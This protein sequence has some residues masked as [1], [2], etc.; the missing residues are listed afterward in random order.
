MLN[1]SNHQSHNHD[2]GL[3]RSKLLLRRNNY[4]LRIVKSTGA[5]GRGPQ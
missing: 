1:M 4:R 3:P 5:C 2:P